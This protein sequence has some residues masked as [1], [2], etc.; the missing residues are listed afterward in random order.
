MRVCSNCFNDNEIKNFIIDESKENEVC[1]CCNVSS[2]TIE[3]VEL[4]DFFSE[5]LDIF[6]I[7]EDGVYL[8]ELIQKDWHIFSSIDCANIILEEVIKR[9]NIV[10]SIND[11]VSYLSDIKECFK[12][13]EKL[14]LEVQ[15]EKRYFADL[16]TFDW[17]SYIKVNMQIPQNTFLYRARIT[18]D[19]KEKLNAKEMGSPPK[20]KATAGR[21]NPIGIPYLYLCNMMETTYYEIR[22]VY[23]DKISVGKFRVLRDLNIVDFSNEIN[24]FYTFTTSESDM[25]LSEIIK[26]KIIFDSIN[27]DISKPLR[28]F[29][30][31]IEYVPTQLICE[32]CKLNGADGI[33]FNSSL[34]N[35]GMNIVL[36]NSNDVKCV[37]V[38]SREIKSVKIEAS[39]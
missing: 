25:T 10:I 2:K 39:K 29:D 11:K 7:D 33:R 23:L 18:P 5:F 8:A 36:F 15:E 32:Y 14:K 12:V 30:T 13:W 21:A 34:H 6:S 16:E 20:S 22:A 26:R 9:N 19:G 24:L 3:I 4:L 31:E 37:S 1:S 38:V 35:G 27:K 28:R 17:E